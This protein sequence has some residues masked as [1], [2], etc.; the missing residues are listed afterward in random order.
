MLT[1]WSS[2]AT[3]ALPSTSNP[4]LLIEKPDSYLSLYI[5]I[6][7]T[8]VVI[9]IAILR[10][11]AREPDGD[12]KSGKPP[13]CLRAHLGRV[14]R[15]IRRGLLPEAGVPAGDHSVLRRWGPGD[16][17]DAAVLSAAG[18][19]DLGGARGGG[20]AGTLLPDGAGAVSSVPAPAWLLFFFSFFLVFSSLKGAHTS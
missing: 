5:Y 17:A 14:P 3:R 15:H 19:A 11:P 16:T 2:F 9:V 8:L 7:I 18:G 20:D 4:T 1:T 13:V 6:Y 12:E 10:H